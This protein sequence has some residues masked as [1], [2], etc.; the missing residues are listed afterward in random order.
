M[1]LL[2]AVSLRDPYACSCGHHSGGSAALPWWV[3]VALGLALVPKA[4]D[5]L[6]L[7]GNDLRHGPLLERRTGLRKLIGSDPTSSLQYSEEFIGD[8]AAFFR[9]WAELG[10]EGVV[11]SSQVHV[12]GAGAARHG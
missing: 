11:L 8:A 12:T 4:F 7:D 5:Q 3:A 9:A 10:L 1:V 2:E 6:H